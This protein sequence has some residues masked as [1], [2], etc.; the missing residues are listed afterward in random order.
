MIQSLLFMQM[1]RWINFERIND[2][3]GHDEGDQVLQTVALTLTDS[4][5]NSDFVARLSGEEFV[6]L[7]ADDGTHAA[8]NSGRNRIFGAIPVF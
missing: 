8:K 6:I 2:Q 7:L 4:V 5:H 3:F 1:V